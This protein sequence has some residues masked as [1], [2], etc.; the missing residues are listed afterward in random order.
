L[1]VQLGGCIAAGGTDVGDSSAAAPLEL[2]LALP[3][4]VAGRAYAPEVVRSRLTEVGCALSDGPSSDVIRVQPPTW[5]PD[6][7]GTAELV[8]E[9]VR[10]EGYDSIPG[11]LPTAPAGRGLTAAQRWRRTASR[12]LAAAGLVEVVN[13]P[14]VSSSVLPDFAGG[15]TPPRLVN[16]LAE[17]EAVLRPSLQP[18]LLAALSRNVGRGLTDVALFE[19]GVVFLSQG[20]AGVAP[21]GVTRRPEP[22]ELA[23]LDAALPLQARHAGIA[24]AGRR[25]GHPVDWADAAEA[26]LDLG[27]ALGLQLVLRAGQFGPWHPGRCAEVLLAGSRVGMVGELHPR[28][29]SGLGVPERTVTAEVNLDVLVQAAVATGAVRAPYVSSYPPSSV[30]VALVVEQSVPAGEVEAALRAGAGSLLE[31][32]RLFDVYTGPQV[33]DGHR[34]LAYSLRFRAADRTLIDSEVLTARDAAVAAAAS[35]TGAVLRGG[36]SA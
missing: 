30:D 24:L 31:D 5:R 32:L 7:T 17:T 29:V 25:C 8:E 23:A 28:V 9:V 6:L 2:P 20:V 19:T 11:V 26:V 15:L 18:G 27:R 22:A 1:L 4:R 36:G 13:T 14:F 35:A 12:A 33:G 10:L 21:P 16:P 34:S 3:G